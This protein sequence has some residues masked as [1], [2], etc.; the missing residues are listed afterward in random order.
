M[1]EKVL[2]KKLMTNL[3]VCVR[4][5]F[6][7]FFQQLKDKFQL[8]DSPKSASNMLD[9]RREKN[10][11][12]SQ[13]NYKRIKNGRHA[14]YIDFTNLTNLVCLVYSFDD[15]HALIMNFK[16]SFKNLF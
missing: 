15:S 14:I 5:F 8:Y 6:F 2:L 4:V 10:N 16:I 13:E 11:T 12:Q 9:L 7:F 1:I 3:I